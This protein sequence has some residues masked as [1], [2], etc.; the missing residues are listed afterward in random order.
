[1]LCSTLAVSHLNL[2]GE[3]CKLKVIILTY[4][5]PCSSVEAVFFLIAFASEIHFE[6]LWKNHVKPSATS[7]G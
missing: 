5:R 7:K 3:S 1:M 2:T 6:K 4:F